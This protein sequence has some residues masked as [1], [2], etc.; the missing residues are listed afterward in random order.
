[1]PPIVTTALTV[2]AAVAFFSIVI[3]WA[4]CHAA[5]LSCASDFLDEFYAASQRLIKDE[6]TP[7]SVID[8][9]RWFAGRAGRPSLARGFAFHLLMGRL[10][11]SQASSVKASKLFEDVESLP[12]ELR[13]EFT[14]LIDNGMKSSAAADPILSRVYLYVLTIFM[15]RTGRKGDAASPD[16]ASTVALD[17]ATRDRECLMPA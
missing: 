7:S 1:M 8:F 4:R 16:R 9:I 17:L 3:S 2:V 11:V 12:P 13:K 14:I 5:D 15:S 10:G 6:K